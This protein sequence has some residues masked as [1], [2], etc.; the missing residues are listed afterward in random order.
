MA[1]AT[2]KTRSKAK[3]TE[4]GATR[5]EVVVRE[6]GAGDRLALDGLRRQAERTHARLMPDYFR[7]AP[8]DAP[9]VWEP[10]QGPWSTVLVAALGGQAAAGGRAGDL[11][12]FVSVKVVVTPRD[13]AMV[14]RRRAHVEVIVVD[15]RHRSA[16]IGTALMQA[17]TAWAREREATEMVLTVWAD[18]VAADA[19]YRSLGYAPIA[20]VLRRKL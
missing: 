14:P 20:R 5:T 4:A 12:G 11:V 15:E 3:V 18:N 6:A 7:E 16:G 9:G 2:A 17:A 8:A 13:P 19:L 1:K 10:G